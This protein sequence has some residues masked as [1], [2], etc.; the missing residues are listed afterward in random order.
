MCPS[1]T[2][3]T[4]NPSSRQTL[5]APA[6]P[7]GGELHLLAALE[8]GVHHVLGLLGD[9]GE[10]AGDGGGVELGKRHADADSIALTIRSRPPWLKFCPNESKS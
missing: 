6:S 7:S 1:R 4:A 5:K 9:L 8:K 2:R 10:G 3:R